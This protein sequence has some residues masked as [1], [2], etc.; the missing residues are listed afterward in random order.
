LDRPQEAG[1]FIFPDLSVRHEGQYKLS[2]NLYEQAKNDDDRDRDVSPNEM[3]ANPPNVAGA[4]DESFD[5]RLEIKSNEFTVYSAK[6]FP[7][8]AES[9]ALSRTV[10]EQGC[11]VRIRRDVRMRRRETK[12]GDYDEQN[13]DDYRPGRPS[14]QEPYSGQPRSR[15]HSGTPTSDDGRAPYPDPHGEYP[16][17]PYPYTASPTPSHTTGTGFQ[18]NY[19]GN[20]GSSQ[21]YQMPPQPPYAQPPAAPQSYPPP[22]PSNYQSGPS[23]FHAPP[24]P[25]SSY[26]NGYDR[27]PQ[28]AFPSVPARERE[29]EYENECR[30]A[31]VGYAPA[32]APQPQSQPQPPPPYPSADTGYPRSY[33]RPLSPPRLAPIKLPATGLKY[34]PKYEQPHDPV[35]SP[36]G[37]LAPIRSFPPLPV[38]NNLERPGERPAPF[39][40]RLAPAYDDRSAY[41]QYSS[42]N[43]STRKRTYEQFNPTAEH[44]PLHNGMRPDAL[45]SDVFNDDVNVKMDYKRADGYTRTRECPTTG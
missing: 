21:Q 8:L 45:R 42:G 5:W 40:E 26:N 6:K 22:P 15:S 32:P 37:P 29:R 10:A 18:G 38:P 4:P 43:E 25:Q 44:L 20:L 13:E 33:M 31:S 39:S 7:G 17:S 12:G 36:A 30:R 35:A 14:Q 24:P 1:Y 23:Q 9:T 16:V 3:K 19:L 11:R 2:F 28:S 34:D 41:N 27:L